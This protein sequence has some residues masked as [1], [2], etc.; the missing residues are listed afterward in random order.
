MRKVVIVSAKRTPIGKFLGG[1]AT[2]PA[3]QL[4][5]IAIKGALEAA[6][7]NLQKSM[8]SLWAMYCK[9]GWASSCPTSRLNGW[10]SRHCSLYDNQ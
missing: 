4:G 2:I 1:L 7:F 5:A 3:P 8:K 10:D 9:L 6:E